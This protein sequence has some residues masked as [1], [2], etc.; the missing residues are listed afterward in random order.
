MNWN[1]ASAEVY[2]EALFDLSLTADVDT[3]MTHSQSWWQRP[4]GSVR[5]QLVHNMK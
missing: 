1:S 2:K 3:E 4:E 5:I